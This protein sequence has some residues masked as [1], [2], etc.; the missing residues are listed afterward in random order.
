MCTQ[1]ALSQCPGLP[2]LASIFSDAQGGLNHGGAQNGETNRPVNSVGVFSK[3]L[4][5][6]RTDQVLDR[7][8]ELICNTLQGHL[9]AG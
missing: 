7:D 4:Q 9:S 6:E 1:L 2:N 3:E 8:R 5:S